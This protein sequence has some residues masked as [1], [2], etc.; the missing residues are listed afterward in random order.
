MARPPSDKRDKLAHAASTLAY[1]RGFEATT[2]SDI[3]TE[4]GVPMG[5]VYYYFKTKDDVGR[6]VVDAMSQRYAELQSQWE[7]AGGPR[8]RLVAYLEM[9]VTDAQVTKDYGCPIGSLCTD[10]RKHNATLG[11]DAAVIFRRTLDWISAQFAELG[12]DSQT[13][14]DNALHLVSGV[15]GSTLLGHAFGSSDP[16]IREMNRLRDWITD[17]TP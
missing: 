10:M 14:E 16:V 12:C 7:A 17:F 1:T 2:I 6:A 4:A 11:D 8:E 13:A 3:A 5:S 9:S 15:Q